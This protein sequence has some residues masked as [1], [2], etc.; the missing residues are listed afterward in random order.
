[1]KIAIKHFLFILVAC[2]AFAQA[3]ANDT[4][5]VHKDARVDVLAEKQAAINKMTSNMTA[6]GLFK[7]YRLQVLNT[8]SRDDAF[9]LKA[10]LLENFPDQK[11]YVLYQSPYFKVRIGNFVQ[12]TD[13]ED[14]R[15]QLS[16]YI[17]NPAYIVD[18]IIE[19][20]PQAGEF[21]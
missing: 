6:D 3:N 2:F 5:I 16:A 10:A 9:K 21:Q 13:A 20:I 4:I 17:S 7:G 18:D 12:R 11:V 8:R 14:F 15:K 1:M 19:Y